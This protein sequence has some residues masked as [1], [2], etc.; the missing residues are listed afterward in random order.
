[1][2]IAGKTI[3]ALLDTGSSV[4]LINKTTYD[5]LKYKEPIKKY[6][7]PLTA[8]NGSKIKVYGVTEIKMKIGKEPLKYKFLVASNLSRSIILGRDFIY[9][10][11]IN[12]Y[13]QLKSI[14]INNSYIPLSNDNEVNSITRLNVNLV[15]PPNT[16]HVVTMR[17]RRTNNHEFSDVAFTPTTKGYLAEQ[18]E[19]FVAPSVAKHQNKVPVQISNTS[20]RT[21]KLKK[22]CVLGTIELISSDVH[23][24]SS[25]QDLPPHNA[26]LTKQEFLQQAKVPEE[27]KSDIEKFLLKNRRN[28]AFHD[29][30]LQRTDLTIA[31]VDTGDTPPINKRPYRTPLNQREFVSTAIDDML[32]AGLVERCNSMWNFPV[33]VVSK[34]PESPGATPKQR[35]CIDFRALNNVTRM[36]SQFLP[37]IDDILGHLNGSTFFTTLDLRSG[38]HQ[39]PLSEEASQKCSFSCHHGKF[40]Y[41]VMPFG[42]MNAPHIFQETMSKLL[43]GLEAF[44]IA[45]IDDVL[46]F[47]KGS[48]DDHISKVQLVMDRI[49]KHKLKL[50]LNKCQWALQQ[51]EY[52]G[53]I[54]SKKGVAPQQ[55]KVKAIRALKPP[56]T[57]KLVRS[58]IGMCSFYRRFIPNFAELSIPLVNLTKKYARFS[59]DES[60]QKAFEEIK[61]QLTVVPLLA[62]PDVNKPYILF[63][64]ASDTCVG[65][66]L[67]QECN[68]DH[69][70]LSNVPNIKPIVFLSH[71]LSDCQSKSYTVTEKEL[72]G[73]YYSVQKLRHYLEGARFIIKTDHRPLEHLF[74]SD[75]ANK[76]CQRWAMAIRGYN[77]EIQ[78]LKGEENVCADL[79]SRSPP[80]Y[81][82]NES[83]PDPEEGFEIN[84]VINTNDL[85]LNQAHVANE[86]QSQENQPI[87]SADNFNIKEK[88]DE[89]ENIKKL[90]KRLL[91][92]TA[93]K[94]EFR[95]HVVKDDVLYYISTP[96]DNPTLRLY[97]PEALKEAVIKQY[98]DRLGHP[99]VQRTFKTIQSKYYWRNLY[100]NVE[101]YV[102]ACITCKTRNLNQKTAPVQETATPTGPMISLQL[103]LSG[104]F[105]TSLSNNK[106]ICSFICLYSGWVEAF[107]IPDKSGQ[108]VLQCFMENILPRYGCPLTIT[109][110]NGGEFVNESFSSAMRKLNIKHITTSVY[111]PRANGAVERSHRTLNDI[112][113]KIQG[114]PE[115]WDLT[116]NQALMAMRASVC[117]TTNKSPHELMFSRPMTLP[118]DNLLRPQLKTTSEDF[119]IVTLQNMN[120]AFTEALRNTRK[121]KKQWVKKA[122]KGR[123]EVTLK[124]GDNVYVKNPHKE[125]KH[126][127]SWLPNYTITEKTGPVSFKVINLLTKKVSRVHAN[128]LRLW[129]DDWKVPKLDK[130]VRK[131]RLAAPPLSESE[132]EDD[133]SSAT[134]PEREDS[135]DDSD[136]T[137]DYDPDYYQ[138]QVRGQTL[139]KTN[140]DDPTPPF[141]IKRQLIHAQNDL[142]NPNDS[143]NQPS[144]RRSVK[145]RRT[146]SSDDETSR[147]T[148]N[149]RPLKRP[150]SDN[151]NDSFETSRKSPHIRPLKRSISDDDSNDAKRPTKFV[152]VEDSE[153][154]VGIT[155]NPNMIHVSPDYN[156]TTGNEENMEGESFVTSSLTKAKKHELACLV[157]AVKLFIK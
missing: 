2:S 146:D 54:V 22:G 80:P 20:N 123:K 149:I 101:S 126:D 79:F 115:T 133:A 64:D 128:R 12:F 25:Y 23:Q 40:K 105:R 151:E 14:K 38:F 1:M 61:A 27:F 141:Q 143:F 81:D 100:V 62:F 41:R 37:S 103:D 36:Q 74:T 135:F 43:Q 130:P 32:S 58:F 139:F 129:E 30:D 84:A 21:I 114:H 95:H 104:P 138:Q 6:D 155:D 148:P 120:K 49:T 57:V 144:V 48:L 18:P 83:L 113:S 55:E 110:D 70:W 93:K 4:T 72:F 136:T 156:T 147:P 13:S 34:K 16:T 11:K 46:I 82:D 44:A 125:S 33:V 69:Q 29:Q 67:T 97:V 31:D 42:L 8:A 10:N 142:Q 92:N 122:N 9:K 112:I 26:K 59:W 66:I 90:K 39:I 87:P 132:E 119:H 75:Q 154:E 63:T 107:A 89:D 106:Y 3:R 118:L 127:A 17:P 45:Y 68:D 76:R 145:R 109:T 121:A 94:A 78:Y 140:N 47:S 98:H 124:E 15:L 51:I 91:N 56:T 71:K 19:V 150:L 60:C 7:F 86:A 65:A 96:D 153:D 99:G 111:N 102:Q 134:T 116:L 24:I 137:I 152:T 35:L 52:L 108:S 77:C 131:T 117:S 53:F 88:Q 85:D 157:E 5:N 50:K 28:F 73:I